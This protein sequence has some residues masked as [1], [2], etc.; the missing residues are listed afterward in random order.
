MINMGNKD[1]GHCCCDGCKTREERVV[2][3]IDFLHND[4]DNNN[5]E[6]ELQSRTRDDPFQSILVLFC[7][8]LFCVY[9]R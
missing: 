4:T 5:D 7:V 9:K 8:G 2:L 3:E 6:S 1:I